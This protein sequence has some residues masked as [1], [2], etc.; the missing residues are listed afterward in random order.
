MAGLSETF[1]ARA[2]NFRDASMALL[3]SPELSTNV[4]KQVAATVG[5]VS[6]TVLDAL[7]DVVDLQGSVKSPVEEINKRSE[8]LKLNAAIRKAAATAY[9]TGNW[10]EYDRLVAGAG[11]PADDSGNQASGGAAN[12]P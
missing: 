6:A 1:R 7:A 11:K 2:K 5:Q 12:S 3:D 8:S 4:Q 10:D 9:D